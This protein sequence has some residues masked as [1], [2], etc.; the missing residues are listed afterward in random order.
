MRKK[1]ELKP[2]SCAHYVR[3]IL[4]TR[5]GTPSKLP[6][7]KGNL[8]FAFYLSFHCVVSLNIMLALATFCQHQLCMH[9]LC[10]NSMSLSQA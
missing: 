4:R 5:S 9:E 1:Q 3:N 7:L 10:T 8:R 2:W 6:R